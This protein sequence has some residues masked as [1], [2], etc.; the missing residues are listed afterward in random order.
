[1]SLNIAGYKVSDAVSWVAAIGSDGAE[2]FPGNTD[3]NTVVENV[4]RNPTI[5]KEVRLFPTDYFSHPALRWDFIGCGEIYN[6]IM[7]YL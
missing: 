3:R 7:I 2:T 4:F 5:A 1:M 6:K